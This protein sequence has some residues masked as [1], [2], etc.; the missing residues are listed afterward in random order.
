[1]K[2]VSDRHQDFAL[3]SD[4]YTKESKT[5]T[6]SKMV[7][8]WFNPARQFPASL[9]EPALK[10]CCTARRWCVFPRAGALAGAPRAEQKVRALLSQRSHPLICKITG[11][12]GDVVGLAG[13]RAEGHGLKCHP[14]DA[15]GACGQPL[16]ASGLS[17]CRCCLRE[18]NLLGFITPPLPALQQEWVQRQLHH[19]D[20]QH[21]TESSH[22]GN[23]SAWSHRSRKFTSLCPFHPCMT[24]LCSTAAVL[25][26]IPDNS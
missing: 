4:L 6:L 18:R 13:G 23:H 3:M 2:D 12:R 17:P 9:P 10:W 16:P 26:H 14:R 24:W 19:Q 8:S 1:M 21:P 20:L 15:P 7:P 11:Q 5:R 22:V 25:H